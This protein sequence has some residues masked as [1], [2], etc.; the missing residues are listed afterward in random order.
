MKYKCLVLTAN[1][2]MLVSSGGTILLPL[3][4][5]TIIDHIR[6]EE[7]LGN[8]ALMFVALTLIMAIFSS[9]RGFCFN[10]LG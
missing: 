1:L 5:G 4:C 10:L 8:D 6:N 3:L 7:S 9:L 2:G